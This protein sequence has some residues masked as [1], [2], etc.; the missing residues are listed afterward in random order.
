MIEKLVIS[1]HIDD[2]IL[3]CGGILD[4]E[5]MVL[6]CGIEDRSTVSAEERL[7]EIEDAK[8]I[9]GFR[10]KLLR[11][12][13]VNSFRVPD[14]IPDIERMINE[15]KPDSVYI[16]HPS[17]NQDHIAAYEAALVALR[18]HDQNHFVKRVFIYEQ[19]HVFLWDHTHDMNNSFKP[20]YFIQINIDRKVKAYKALTSQVRSFRSPEMLE[21][22]ASLRGKQSGY[23][24]AEAYKILRWVE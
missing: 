17:Y 9:L 20:N 23:E 14:L 12:N 8:S 1:P 4:N 16:P 19:P 21:Q 10:S 3:G 11:K 24:Y 6:H 18:P 2:E 7:Q 5:T 22:M 13:V 15:Y